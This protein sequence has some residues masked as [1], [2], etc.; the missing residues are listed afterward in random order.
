LPAC[1]AEFE[2]GGWRG[3]RRCLDFAAREVGSI[4]LISFGD[5]VYHEWVGGLR[6]RRYF[7][8]REATA[9]RRMTRENIF[10]N[11]YPFCGDSS[12]GNR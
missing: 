5:S 3:G 11:V 10:D 6:L 8:F 4:A 1:A 7:A 12:Y 2:R 9:A